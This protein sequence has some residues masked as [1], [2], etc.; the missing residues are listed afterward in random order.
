MWR[1]CDGCDDWMEADREFGAL[2]CS[3]ECA[4]LVQLNLLDY[5]EE[6]VDQEAKLRLEGSLD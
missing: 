6:D 1:K 4:E 2:S 3:P 5:S